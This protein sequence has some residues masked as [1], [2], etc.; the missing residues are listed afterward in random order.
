MV[1]DRGVES[2]TARWTK[3]FGWWGVI[4]NRAE[5]W[6]RAPPPVRMVHRE[7]TP[8]RWSDDELGIAAATR[9]G[10]VTIP[11]GRCKGVG[12]IK[13]TDCIGCWGGGFVVVCLSDDGRPARCPRCRGQGS[14]TDV[15]SC[16]Y[17]SN[18]AQPVLER[19]PARRTIV[20]RAPRSAR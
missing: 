14:Y 18:P 3:S 17:C 2:T 11:C 4:C 7:L 9:I 8:W 16:S 6:S 10:N 12:L 1:V 15:D 5:L 20:P 19:V 13:D